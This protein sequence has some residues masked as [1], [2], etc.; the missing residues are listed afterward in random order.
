MPR[1]VY[2]RTEEHKRKL[3]LARKSKKLSLET[4]LKMSKRMKGNTFGFKKGASGFKLKHTDESKNRMSLSPDKTGIGNLLFLI[5][6]PNSLER[7]AEEP[8]E[9][10]GSN[11]RDVAS[12][13]SPSANILISI[14]YG[15]SV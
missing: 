8:T 13:L 7:E 5:I 2:I 4:K 1:G 3:S 15:S 9:Y 14:K 12:R 10:V 6:S 11:L